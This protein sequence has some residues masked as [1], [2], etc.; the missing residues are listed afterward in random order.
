ML[1]I[2]RLTI[3]RIFILI[4]VLRSAISA[5]G[6]SEISSCCFTNNTTPELLLQQS[7]TRL[8]N[9]YLTSSSLASSSLLNTS[10]QEVGGMRSQSRWLVD[11]LRNFNIGKRILVDHYHYY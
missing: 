1:L 8:E 6:I 4:L 7:I 5:L 3:R 2:I 11:D 9:L 10:Y